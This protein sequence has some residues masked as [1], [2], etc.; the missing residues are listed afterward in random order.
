MIGKVNEL[1]TEN[2][3]LKEALDEAT[4]LLREE[5]ALWNEEHAKLMMEI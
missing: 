4:E 1:E 3:E 5:R 2:A